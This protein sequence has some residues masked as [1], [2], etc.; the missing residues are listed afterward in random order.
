VKSVETKVHSSRKSETSTVTKNATPKKSVQE[1]EHVK[2]SSKK[3]EAESPSRQSS[4]LL[5]KS[6][7]T[8]KESMLTEVIVSSFHLGCQFWVGQLPHLL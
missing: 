4:R 2:K 3:L 8:E 6:Q 5:V 7:L 1:Q